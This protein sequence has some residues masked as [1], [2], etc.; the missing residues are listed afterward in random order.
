MGDEVSVQIMTFYDLEEAIKVTTSQMLEEVGCTH[1][2]LAREILEDPG[3]ISTWSLGILIYTMVSRFTFS[4]ALNPSYLHYLVGDTQG[5]QP[6][7][8]LENPYI[9]LA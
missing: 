1:S 5:H 2:Y 6:C 3:S 4:E 8:T 9:L 7:E